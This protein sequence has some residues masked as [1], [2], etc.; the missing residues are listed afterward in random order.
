MYDYQEKVKDYLENNFSPANYD[1]ANMRCTTKML[2]DFIFTVFPKDCI[3]D[4]ELVETLYDLGYVPK[5]IEEAIEDNNPEEGEEWKKKT[6]P[7][8][9]QL[10]VYW[11]LMA[12]PSL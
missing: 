6:K 11:C 1:L 9:T 8:K 10:K 4:Y 2:L 12:L 7:K 5:N 3:S